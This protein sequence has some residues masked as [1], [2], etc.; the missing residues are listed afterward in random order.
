MKTYNVRHGFTKKVADVLAAEDILAA[1]LRFMTKLEVLVGQCLTCM[2]DDAKSESEKETKLISLAKKSVQ[3]LAILANLEI[4]R[5]GFHRADVVNV[6]W[7]ELYLTFTGMHD[8]PNS[9]KR[10]YAGIEYGEAADCG[11]SGYG[12]FCGPFSPRRTG[13]HH[14]KTISLLE[15][16][17]SSLAGYIRPD[18]YNN[19]STC[20]VC[21]LAMMNYFVNVLYN[22]QPQNGLKV[23]LDLLMSSSRPQEGFV[24]PRLLPTKLKAG[25]AG[26]SD[27]WWGLGG[28]VGWLWLWWDHRSGCLDRGVVPPGRTTPRGRVGGRGQQRL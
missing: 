24:F 27:L 21:S 8:C 25:K 16:I 10:R 11:C 5:N 15:H 28:S 6:G 20:P 19:R 22:T 1:K 18:N 9:A 17:L 4:G 13:T 12:P 7:D 23:P 26:S 2:K 3:A 14:A